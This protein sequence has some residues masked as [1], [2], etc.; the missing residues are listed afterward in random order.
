MDG[1]I[2]ETDVAIG[3]VKSWWKHELLANLVPSFM[4]ASFNL[5]NKS[6]L[7]GVVSKELVSRSLVEVHDL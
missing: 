5:K 2:Q 6:S 1:G 7:A 4:K 3:L